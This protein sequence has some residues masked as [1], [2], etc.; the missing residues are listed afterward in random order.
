MVWRPLF[1]PPDI[2]FLRAAH[3]VPSVEEII[4]VVA[5][6]LVRYPGLQTANNFDSC[7]TSAHMDYTCTWGKPEMFSRCRSYAPGQTW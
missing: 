6:Q 4:Y 5:L 3:W 1:V 2:F 7:G